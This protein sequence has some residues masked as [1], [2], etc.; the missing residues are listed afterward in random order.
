M[1]KEERYDE[2]VKKVSNCEHFNVCST[3]K[4]SGIKKLKL[5]PDCNEINLWTYWEG[6]RGSL[7]AEILV[8]GQDWGQIKDDKAMSEALKKAED[9]STRTGYMDMFDDPGN[10][11]DETL[12]RLF[13]EIGI[14]EV[15]SDYRTGE[16]KCRRVF[17]T[18]YICCYRAGKTSGE[19]DDKWTKNCRG[20]FEELVSIIEPRVIVCLGQKVFD[21]VSEAA[22]LPVGKGK[23]SDTV[24][25]GAVMMN[26]NGVSVKVFPMAHPGIRGLLNTCRFRDKADA[27]ASIERGRQL[28][29]EDWK[30]IIRD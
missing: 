14:P 4:N 12:C 8:V 1:T 19:V 3:D 29:T 30:K 7:D 15:E 22:G 23:Y 13:R 17:F 16:R 11:T 10:D 26:I 20:Y 27:K 24:A 25:K 21:S 5:C 2:L 28:Q 6:G 18:N 9:P